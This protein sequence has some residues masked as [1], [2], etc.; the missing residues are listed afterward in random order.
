DGTPWFALG[1]FDYVKY[2]GDTAFVRE[3]FPV[4]R[5]A[6]EGALRHRVDA[7]MFLTH[8]DAESWMDAV[9]PDGPWSARGNRANDVQALWYRQLMVSTA[10]A[11]MQGDL[12]AADRWNGVA[13]TLLRNFQRRFVDAER[14]TIVD[15][16]NADGS[17]D[18]AIRP[19]QLFAL[20]IVVDPKDRERIFKN[21]TQT[22]V[23]E[24]GV[25]SLSSTDTAFHPYHQYP[26][27]YPK[28]AAYH[29]GI[30]WT[31]LAGP[32]IKSAVE[33]GRPNLAFRVTENLVH[34]ILDRGG[35]GT[36][37]E[38]IDA[39][40]RPGEKEP[41]LSGTFSQ[42]WSLAEFIRATYQSYLGV[43]VD[44]PNHQLW[45]LPQLPMALN[46]ATFDVYVG[47]ARVRVSYGGDGQTGRIS[48][49]SLQQN[50]PI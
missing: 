4:L 39:A 28:D 30:V 24:H 44:A 7:E 10:F 16:L 35:V 14:G 17:A 8:A 27:F 29:N 32:W 49:L 19:N 3:I 5:R 25:A 23:Y 42:A 50:E 34:Q 21:I 38:L 45:L 40:P 20:D 26:P 11:E 2:S 31:W 18:P 37:S 41:R 43:S 22:L 1:V 13:Q 9:G 12:A 48:L 46:A 33:F 15:H 36:V 47:T 6:V